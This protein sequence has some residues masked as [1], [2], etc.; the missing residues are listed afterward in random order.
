M[1]RD[2]TL[3]QRKF[4]AAYL[5][6]GNGTEA[7]VRSYNAANRN[8]AHAIANK[9]L[10]RPAIQAAVADYL[11][12]GGLSGERLGELH[13]RFLDLTDGDSPSDRRTALRALDMAYKLLGVY[14]A[15]R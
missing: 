14:S 10:R 8:T 1:A 15:A 5:E 13:G 11:D 2:L 12:G 4:L 9:N 6:T 7:A 3:K